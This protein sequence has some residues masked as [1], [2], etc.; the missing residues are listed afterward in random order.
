MVT[1]GCL[2]GG[3]GGDAD[4]TDT[5]SPGDAGDGAGGSGDGDAGDGDTG[6]G[7]SSS[8]QPGEWT[9]FD[10]DEP[11]T[12]TYDVYME[13]EGE[14]ELIWDVQSVDG[15][16]V[17]VRMVYDVAGERFDSTITG[18]KE[19]VQSQLYTNPAGILLV[20]TMFTPATWYAGQDLSEGTKWSYTT[21]D[22]SASFAVTGT[23][24]YANVECY[25]SEM[26]VDQQVLHEGCFAPQLGLAPYTAYYNEDGS[27]SMEM[28]LV[29]YEKN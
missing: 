5:Q 20:T 28:K 12:Y 7:D 10:F 23:N 19:T 17:T 9:V 29:S 27:L 1:A 25:T 14:G 8:L 13:G 3:T 22:G 11:A 26:T 24:T 2:S 18:T 16:T 21:Q 15:D 4:P 6:S